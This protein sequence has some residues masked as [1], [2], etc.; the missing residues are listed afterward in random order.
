VLLDIFSRNAWSVPATG[1]NYLNESGKFVL[2]GRLHA[3]CFNRNRTV[4]SSVNVN[5]KLT[6]RPEFFCLVGNRCDNKASTT[7]LDAILCVAEGELWP[8]LLAAYYNVLGITRQAHCGV[9]CIRLRVS[10]RLIGKNIC[11][12]TMHTI[13]RIVKGCWTK[14]LKAPNSLVLH[15]K[16]IAVLP[17][18]KDVYGFVS[19]RISTLFW[20]THNLLLV[21]FRS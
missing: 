21:Q 1:L 20:F 12:R 15:H 8:L 17:S 4:I 14:Q 6:R 5:N 11:L 19:K 7:I 2:C 9:T 10:L 13:D 3:A 16:Y 18:R